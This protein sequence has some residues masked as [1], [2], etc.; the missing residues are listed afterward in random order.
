MA[1]G[2]K[3]DW[4]MVLPAGALAAQGFGGEPDVQHHPQGHSSPSGD[5]H[6]HNPTLHTINTHRNKQKTRQTN[7]NN[8]WKGGEERRQKEKRNNTLNNTIRQQTTLRGS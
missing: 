6:P 5:G 1:G 4:W 8:N 3:T 7:Q 2:W